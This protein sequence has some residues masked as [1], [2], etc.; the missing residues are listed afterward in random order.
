MIP[1][2]FRAPGGHIAEVAPSAWSA[3]C[4]LLGGPSRVAT[5]HVADY[6]VV[7]F[8]EPVRGVVGPELGIFIHP[9]RVRDNLQHAPNAYVVKLRGVEI[10]RGTLQPGQFLAMDPGTVSTPI[11]GTP[12]REPVFNLPAIWIPE[13]QKE[14]AENVVG[15]CAG[16][17]LAVQ[18]DVSSEEEVERLFDRTLDTFDRIDILSR[19]EPDL[20]AAARAVLR[21]LRG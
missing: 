3:I 16:N 21:D 9:V 14:K 11:Q 20:K 19:T 15:E 8:R 17:A 2:K 12:G 5:T 13:D 7:N 10:A 18:A 6:F 1:V 4:Q